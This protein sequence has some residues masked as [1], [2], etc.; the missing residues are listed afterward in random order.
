[1]IAQRRL[2][3]GEVARSGLAI[4]V[5]LGGRRRGEDLGHHTGTPAKGGPGKA[6]DPGPGASIAEPPQAGEGNAHAPGWA[7]Y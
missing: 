6:E 3:L 2:K 7:I 5:R 4:E 1:M